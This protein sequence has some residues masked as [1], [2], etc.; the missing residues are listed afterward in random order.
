[1]TTKKIEKIAADEAAKYEAALQI[2]EILDRVE[3]QI[4]DRYDEDDMQALIFGE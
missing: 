1:M 2:R 3:K 4:G